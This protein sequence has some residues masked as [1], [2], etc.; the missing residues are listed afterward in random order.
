MSPVSAAAYPVS[1]AHPILVCY[2]PWHI[3]SFITPGPPHSHSPGQQ[4]HAHCPSSHVL[5]T[6]PDFKI[7]LGICTP[8]AVLQSSLEGPV[9]HLSLLEEAMNKL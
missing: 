4:H 9:C 5:S 7:S 6:S 3:M 8:Q 1:V 2:G